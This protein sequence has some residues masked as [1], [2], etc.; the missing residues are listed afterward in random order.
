MMLG[1]GAC[2]PPYP[3][4]PAIGQ[5]SEGRLRPLPG[6]GE[7]PVPRPDNPAGRHL[8]GTTKEEHWA[9]LLR[10]KRSEDRFS[11]DPATDSCG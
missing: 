11:G 10:A 6:A 9:S 1:P 3:M 4:T 2:W 5:L 7:L 8:G